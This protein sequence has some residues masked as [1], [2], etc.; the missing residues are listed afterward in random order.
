MHEPRPALPTVR[1]R[2]GVHLAL[3]ARIEGD[4]DGFDG[5]GP[6]LRRVPPSANCVEERLSLQRLLLLQPV[7]CNLEVGHGLGQ[8]LV[9]GMKGDDIGC[10][11]RG[12]RNLLGGK[13]TPGG[14]GSL[15]FTQ[16]RDVFSPASNDS[17]QALLRGAHERGLV[18]MLGVTPTR[19]SRDAH[20]TLL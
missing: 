19:R 18:P 3:Q 1:E 7:D 16:L 13:T 5:L 12:L 14:S 11:V 6:E 2:D 4:D 17:L 9:G 20:V 8:L 10:H 15:N